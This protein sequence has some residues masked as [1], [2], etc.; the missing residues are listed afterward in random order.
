M[1]TDLQTFFLVDLLVG[2]TLLAYFW[3]KRG[4]RPW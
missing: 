4:G 1:W 2:S 3:I